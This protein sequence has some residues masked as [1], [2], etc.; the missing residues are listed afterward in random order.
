MTKE[1]F[2]R[3]ALEARRFRWLGGI[4]LAQPLRPWLLTGFAVF[5]ASLVVLFLLFGNYTRRTRVVGQ[6]VPMQGMATV[7]APATGVLVSVETSEGDQ[8][9]A[10]QTLA[11]VTVPRAT[12]GTGNTL[13]AL[14][15]RMTRRALGLEDAQSARRQL[16]D[17]QLTGLAAQATA[18]RRELA[19]IEREIL[20]RRE[21]VRLAKG[22][23]ERLRLLRADQY[24]SDLQLRQQ[25]AAA[26]EQVGEMQSMERQAL[27]ARRQ[28][29]QFNQAMDELPSQR[30]S[31]EATFR[32]EMAQLEQER[33]EVL[34]RGEMAVKAPASGV[35]TAQMFKPGQAVQAG[36][37]L[38]SVLPGDGRLEAELLV[39]SRAIGFVEPGDAVLLR[40]QAFPYQKFGHHR[41]L[42]SRISRSTVGAGAPGGASAGEPLYRVS[43]A[44]QRQAITA[45]GL[46]EP[47]MPG[48]QLE[49]DVMGER[50][51]LIEWVLEPIYSL[52][53]KVVD[54]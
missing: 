10:G 38:M 25:E 15:Q 21:Q 22:L 9:E 29:A 3:E 50:R 7:L 34:D 37:P 17:T 40:Y 14:D 47:L 44:L 48:M 45:Y 1:L 13:A 39:P 11:V 18:A 12:V 31:A 36:Q 24:V 5:A 8:V 27:S 54:P 30:G 41:G 32:R 16:F 42:V 23:L 4:S 6:L 19:Q 49:A 26:L 20:T 2:R 46:P 33:V 43:V 35:V 52:Q 53:G 51:S 28:I